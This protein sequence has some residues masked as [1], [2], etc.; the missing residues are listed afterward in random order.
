M[1][2]KRMMIICIFLLAILAIGAVSAEDASDSINDTLVD[3]AGDIEED[4]GEMD[5]DIRVPEEFSDPTYYGEDIVSVENMPCDAEG[6]ISITVDGV[7][8][9][10][11][12]V[13]AGCNAISLCDLN[14][15]YGNHSLIIKYDGDSKYAGFLKEYSFERIYLD[16][17]C[18]DEFSVAE[19]DNNLKVDLSKGVTGNIKILIDN[20]S[21]YNKKYDAKN[22]PVIALEKYVGSHTY[23][24]RYSNG[25]QKDM[26]KKGSFIGFLLSKPHTDY[27]E[28]DYG[29][30]VRFELNLPEGAKGSAK[31][32]N[33]SYPF[34][35]NEDE[36]STYVN[37]KGF[38][39]GDN[40]IEFTAEWNGLTQTITS[41][42][43]AKPKITLPTALLA[44]KNYSLTFKAS[45]DC[46]GD[47]IFSGMVDGTFKVTNGAATVPISINDAGNYSLEVEYENYT[48]NYDISVLDE[49]PEV[50]IDFLYNKLIN[51]WDSDFDGDPDHYD[52]I[53]MINVNANPYDLTGK[54][55]IYLDG[56]L[57]ATLSG[58]V[59]YH[60][61]PDYGD[62][63][64]HTIKVAYLG[65]DTFKPVTK[66]FDYVVS[67]YLCSVRNGKLTVTVPGDAAGTL[68]V[69]C[70]GKTQTR[71]VK[72]DDW[73]PSHSF[74]FNLDG[75]EKG[76][77]CTVDI[78]FKATP[79]DY[80]FTHSMAV[81]Q[82]CPIRI[83]DDGEYVYSESNTIKFV[84]PK[85]IESNPVVK[86]DGK[87]YA[88][89]K[90]KYDEDDWFSEFN[91]V[92]TQIAYEVDIKDLKPG[93]HDIV[94]SYP[95][96]SK[97][98]SN[99]SGSTFN[100]TVGIVESEDLGI[101]SLKL[102]DDAK[103]S[104]IFEIKY[105]GS[106]TYVLFKNETLKD[107]FASVKL[108]MGSFDY[109]AYYSG[110]D[111]DVD[112]L[113]SSYLIYPDMSYGKTEINYG[114]E[115]SIVVNDKLNA[116]L[117]IFI[118]NEE[119]CRLPIAKF[120]LTKINKITINKNLVDQALSHSMAKSIM[121]NNYLNDGYYS[122]ELN[123]VIYSDIGS[124]Y[125]DTIYVKFPYKITGAGNINMYYGDSRTISLKV[126]GIYGKLV[127]KNQ[128]VKIKI[129]K[130]TFSAKTNKNG[131]VKFKIP[132][133][134]TPG[135]YNVKISYKNL[136]ITKKITVKQVLKLKAVKVKKSAKKLV[137]TAT[138][139]KGKKAIR[140]KWI[141][142]KFK[143]KTY[144][145]VKTNKKGIAKLTIKKSVLKK[146]KVGKKVTYQATYL[147]DT[148]KRT[149]K[150]K[151]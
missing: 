103:G 34:I 82:N 43:Y 129:G 119:G 80:S 137:L 2:F 56:K 79:A 46:N 64:S 29:D 30:S 114:S 150:V 45:P 130:K 33:K 23:E 151:K 37:L 1:K 41:H 111:Y 77:N 71:K 100:V 128:V 125:L 90:W 138:L 126:Y 75:I 15:G 140:G 48:W 39:V 134:I 112:E 59:G 136:A 84:L 6:N 40:I 63:G 131:V 25:N 62:F 120:D 42:I 58:P 57:N 110:N 55:E 26:I 143:G 27:D 93:I 144:K 106:S 72:A 10:N 18:P 19:Y 5:Y 105:E 149:A 68:T 141:T 4:I 24:V 47:L 118:G 9:Y 17:E 81:S 101:V 12:K 135:K 13:M 98:P 49:S 73:D 22:P 88:C 31:F 53:Y 145:K 85:G 44:G 35:W 14:L 97:Y 148:V 86:I 87:N 32:K 20:K 147:K 123:P 36:W 127:G 52:F 76:K 133:T 66:T 122:L 104:L 28:I 96:D 92:N 51:P 124:L 91:D 107:G 99:S 78:S 3:E 11:Q 69:K 83:Y 67:P 102:P 8:K 21:V 74:E 116:T 109:K 89:S 132:S 139:K 16:V 108:P 38:D 113:I 61:W 115:T 95:G 146:L 7:D 121:N 54:T 94:V 65:D 117:V 70:N 60:L 142:F 50:F